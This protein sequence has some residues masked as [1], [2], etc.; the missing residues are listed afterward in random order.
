MPTTPPPMTTTFMRATYRRASGCRERQLHRGVEREQPTLLARTLELGARPCQDRGSVLVALVLS[1]PLADGS[2]LLLPFQ[3][4][5]EL[6]RP[7]LVS[8][9]GSGAS[10]DRER[11]DGPL[12]VADPAGDSER[13]ACPSRR[14]LVAAELLTALGERRAAP[15]PETS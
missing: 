8:V 14:V 13:L 4:A 7:G 15:H 5:P 3:G 11:V 9:L 12:A 10:Q 6:A 1:F 2:T